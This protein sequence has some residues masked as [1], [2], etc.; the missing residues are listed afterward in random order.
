MH[1]ET[2]SL[3]NIS[4]NPIICVQSIFNGKIVDLFFLRRGVG[5]ITK[6][7][8]IKKYSQ[9]QYVFADMIQV[10]QQCKYNR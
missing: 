9:C 10:F 3:G 7:K 1:T 5:R 8:Y 4:S 6:R 2:E